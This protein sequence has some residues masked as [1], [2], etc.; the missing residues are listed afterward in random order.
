MLTKKKFDRNAVLEYSR[1]LFD[2]KSC[3]FRFFD[4]GN[5]TIL[6]NSFGV[7]LNFLL[8]HLGDYPT[9]KI[10]IVLREQQ[11]SKTGLFV[12]RDFNI[13]HTMAPDEEYILWQFTYF[14]TM[15][16]DMIEE[17]PQYSFGFLADLKDEESMKRWLRKQDFRD[18]WY[19]SNKIMFLLYFLTYEQER[20][21]IDNDG[22]LEYL[23]DFLDSK[24]DPKTGFWGTQSGASLE[25]GMFGAAHVYLYYD[26]HGRRINHQ[27]RIVDNV[28]K[29]Q[30]AHGLFGFEVGGACEDYD[31]VEILSMLAKNSN[32]RHDLTM[33]TLDRTYDA[34]QR[35]QC[36]DGGFSYSIDNR[37]V[38]RKFRDRITGKERYYS[39]SGWDR[40]RAKRFR[41]DLWGTYFRVLTLAKIEKILDSSR[42]DKYIFYSLPGWG[43]Y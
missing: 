42:K 19:T 21:S 18:F 24:Q 9:D 4:K 30:N 29:L 43:Y 41:S 33:R 7:Q 10:R 35:A 3:E 8:N 27:N 38:Y 2:D 11:E 13:E 39:Y 17:K 28:V 22:L 20:Q 1:K 36:K 40:M 31:A 32:R 16:M 5:S 12:D 14:A 23:F 26:F 25:N 6:S 34:I 15:A 37:S